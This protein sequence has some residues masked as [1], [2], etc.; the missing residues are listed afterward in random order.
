MFLV[1]LLKSSA[2]STKLR[3]LPCASN[4]CTPILVNTSAF[5]GLAIF[6]NMLDNPV[7]ASLP[8]TPALANTANAAEVSYTV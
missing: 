4:T 1:L 6:S 2:I 8:L 7:P 5:F 3:I